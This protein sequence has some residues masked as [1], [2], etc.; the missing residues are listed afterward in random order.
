MGTDNTRSHVRIH[1]PQGRRPHLVLPGGSREVLDLSAE[2]LLVVLP[3]GG[4]VPELGSRLEGTLEL[5][6]AGPLAVRA[7]VVWIDGDRVGLHLWPDAIPY[8][9][10][11]AEERGVAPT[12]R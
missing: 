7:R 11:L 1:Y 2:G 10:L 6:T 8:P 5:R 4:P 9:V 12:R 3:P